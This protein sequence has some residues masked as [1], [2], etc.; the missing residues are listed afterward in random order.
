VLRPSDCHLEVAPTTTATRLLVEFVLA[1]ELIDLLLSS[2]SGKT[3]SRLVPLRFAEFPVQFID[4]QFALPGLSADLEK[5]L[6]VASAALRPNELLEQ[7][8]FVL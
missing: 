6:H 3:G 5:L 4:A 8:T 7:V 1:P 2:A